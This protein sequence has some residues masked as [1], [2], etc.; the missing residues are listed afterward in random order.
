MS[1]EDYPSGIQRLAE[2]GVGDAVRQ[3]CKVEEINSGY[4]ILQRLKGQKGKR[5]ATKNPP[6]V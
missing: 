5:P 3:D 2:L 1:R 6:T 4:E